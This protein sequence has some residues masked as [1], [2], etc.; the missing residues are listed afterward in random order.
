MDMSPIL[1]VIHTIIIGTMPN[2][3]DGDNG[4][5]LETLRVNRPSAVNSKSFVIIVYFVDVNECTDQPCPSDSACVNSDGTYECPCN[6]GFTAV[7]NLC[8]GISSVWKLCEHSWS[9]HCS[10]IVIAWTIAPTISCIVFALVGPTVGVNV[11]TKYS[12]NYNTA[13]S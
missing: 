4:H 1:S 11:P 10:T 6:E 9:S 3:N 7:N 2:F 8:R 13:I 5:W 12:T